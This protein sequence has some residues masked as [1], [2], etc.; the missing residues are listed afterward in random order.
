MSDQPKPIRY[1]MQ[2]LR[3]GEF[4]LDAGSMFGLIPRVVW[5][6]AAPTDDRG[7]ITVQHN[8]LLLERLDEPPRGSTL[9][10]PKLAIIE[11][12]T[13]NK[14]DPK[15][16]DIFAMSERWIGTALQEV[17]CRAEDIGGV[18]TTHL[19]FDHAGGLTRLSN[20]GEKPDWTGPASTFG[21]PRGDHGVKLTFPNAKVFAQAREWSDALA[22]RSVMTRTYFEDHLHPVREQMSLVESSRPFAPGY[23]PDR[24]ETPRGGVELRETEVMPG[25][26]VF[27]VP[28][29]TWGQQ[30][31]RFVDANGRSVV[32][33]PDVM[34]TAWHVGAAYNLGYDV[35]PYTS[36]VSRR[37]FLEEAER[38]KWLLCLDHEAGN[39]LRTVK[40]NGK[41][42]WDLEE[43]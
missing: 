27:S 35:E 37:W 41:G 28:G 30:A 25:I 29:H 21:G 5:S 34:P 10:A 43:A 18:V 12:G 33:T 19:H 39:P 4:R 16:R 1:S 24:D 8:C 13:G 17:N 20:P 2:L 15:N 31:I 23:V 11:V 3:A 42:W 26:F 32:F 38:N 36:M 14:L 40:S 22:N 6:R 9:H 7:R